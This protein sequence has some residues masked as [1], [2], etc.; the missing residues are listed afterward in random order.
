[1]FIQVP[2]GGPHFGKVYIVW[3]QFVEN[4]EWKSPKEVVEDEGYNSNLIHVIETLDD[5]DPNI[6]NPSGPWLDQRCR[7]LGLWPDGP[8]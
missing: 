6:C 2:G 1:M 5:L 8:C 7:P 3:S 4:L